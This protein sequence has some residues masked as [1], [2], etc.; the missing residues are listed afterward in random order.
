MR[1][2][3]TGRQSAQDSC[4]D[5]NPEAGV[6]LLG[7]LRELGRRAEA[8]PLDFM[9]WLPAQ[10]S[11]LS[12]T[13]RVVLLRC[14][15]QSQGKTTAALAEAI[16]RCI[17]HHPLKAIPSAPV[18][19]WIITASWSQSLAI[20]QKLWELLPK[21]ALDPS[22]EF[23][24][25][26][27]FRGR[28][29]AV[30]FLNGSLLRIKTA[31][32]GGLALAGAT[33]D[34]AIFDE[35]PPDARIYG[36]VQKRV[37]HRAGTVILSLTP[38]NA[39]VDWL[40]EEVEA[41]RIRDLHFR[42]EPQNLCFHGTDQPIRLTDG[43]LCDATWIEQVEAETLSW[44]APVTI[45]GEFEFRHTDRI[46]EN[47]HETEHVIPNL[48]S[49]QVAPQGSVTLTFGAD[50]G[51][52][53]LRTA[54]CLAAIDESGKHPKV[55][56]I[57]EYSPDRSS[58]LDMDAAAVLSMLSARGVQWSELDYAWG[59]VA[60]SGKRGINAKKSNSAMLEALE[61]ALGTTRGLRPI[62]RGVKTGK[63]AGRGAV[64]RGY[65]WLN[66]AMIRPG[67][68]FIDAACTRTIECFNKFNGGDR[69]P[70]KDQIDSVRYACRHLITPTKTHAPRT[71]YRSF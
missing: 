50:Y 54:A 20:Q 24:P 1:D 37:Q 23:D 6:A 15:N 66:D 64:F 40:R 70:E 4:A 57:G 11:L 41:G 47:F 16:Y 34:F 67:H 63:G 35:P 45:H 58:T 9:R 68:F 61:D 29:P 33:I 27:G 32:Q 3:G 5:Q 44:E 30:R 18:E 69:A 59:D 60:Y 28:N 19:G 12:A 56:I 7:A 22:V 21:A 26:K 36:E 2:G 39:P 42:L 10:H 31:R 43:T 25:V 8:S 49:S 52:D 48:L 17:G 38:V 51:L 13:E 53:R 65:R 62:I 71:L 14:G 46:F 55:Y